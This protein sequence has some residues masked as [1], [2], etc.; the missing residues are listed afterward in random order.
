MSESV[1]T[2]SPAKEVLISASADC[3]LQVIMGHG[4]F[5]TESAAI[6][7]ALNHFAEHLERQATIEAVRQGVADA[8]AGRTYTVEEVFKRLDEKYPNLRTD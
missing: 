3:R 2:Q 8:E 6:D 7:A 5:S 1:S 4:N